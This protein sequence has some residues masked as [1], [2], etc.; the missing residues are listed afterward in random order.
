MISNYRLVDRVEQ[1]FAKHN[2]SS[3]PAEGGG[4]EPPSPCGRRFSS[5]KPC[6]LPSQT[7]LDGGRSRREITVLHSD[8]SALSEVGDRKGCQKDVKRSTRIALRSCVRQGPPASAP[9]APA[10]GLQRRVPP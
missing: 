1:T 8:L 2:C 10:C 7:S 9:A 6:L 4:L 3:D 5:S